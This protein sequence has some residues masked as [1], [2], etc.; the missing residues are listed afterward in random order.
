MNIAIIS[1]YFN[2]H[3][4][5]GIVTAK[6]AR[7]LSEAG[8][9]VTVFG[10]LIGNQKIVDKNSNNLDYIKI[11]NNTPSWWK[12]LKKMTLPIALRKKI[13]AIPSLITYNSSDDYGWVIETKKAILKEHRK[14]PFDIIHSRLN[15]HSSH[16]VALLLKRTNPKIYN[17]DKYLN[18]S[19]LSII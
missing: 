13:L 2:D 11:M 6:L 15:P 1:Y 10:N 8:H 18:S 16:Q 12:F 14:R 7:G 4:A 19:S 9:T 17:Y 3:H 5:E